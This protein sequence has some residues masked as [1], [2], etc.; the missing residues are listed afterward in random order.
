VLLGDS[1]TATHLYHIVQEATN[2][3][4]RHGQPKR[5]DIY[6]QARLNALILTI[7]DDGVG[8][9]ADANRQPGVGLRLMQYRANLIGG[10]LQISP[11]G[12]KGTLVTCTVPQGCRRAPSLAS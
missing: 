8:M 6:L 9:P 5:I 11:A 7:S 12:E 4:L 2:N 3:A 10:V 1:L